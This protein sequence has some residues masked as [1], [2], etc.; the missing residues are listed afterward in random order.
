MMKAAGCTEEEAAWL[1][2]AEDDAAIQKAIEE[3]I[4]TRVSAFPL[5]LTFARKP[6]AQRD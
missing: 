3:R 4:L 6:D 5:F 2:N 1:Y